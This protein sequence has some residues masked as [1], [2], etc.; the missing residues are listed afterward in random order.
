MDWWVGNKKKMRATG[1]ASDLQQLLIN[2]EI[3]INH[4]P[5][6]LQVRRTKSKP[7]D[8]YLKPQVIQ[9]VELS[10]NIFDGFFFFFSFLQVL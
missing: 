2:E 1:S 4:K 10:Y 6:T 8:I 5:A 7:E 9:V 3:S